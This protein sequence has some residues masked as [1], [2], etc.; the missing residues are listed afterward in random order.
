MP[1]RHSRVLTRK[2]MLRIY[3][4]HS[5]R[6]P[7]HTNKNGRVHGKIRAGN[8]TMEGNHWIH[9]SHS[10]IHKHQYTADSA[11]AIA[12]ITGTETPAYYL[13][14]TNTEIP[15]LLPDKWWRNAS[16]YRDKNDKTIKKS[17]FFSSV[18]PYENT[19]RH[20]KFPIVGRRALTYDDK[21]AKFN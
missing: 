20:Q 7:V 14:C 19:N 6:L 21:I 1:V 17:P 4:Y 8:C 18:A 3:I 2:N 15:V 16:K 5:Q 13:R 12:N 11:V 10:K 9:T